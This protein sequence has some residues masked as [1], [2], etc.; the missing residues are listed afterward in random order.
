MKLL[1]EVA[2]PIG[3]NALSLSSG[4]AATGIAVVVLAPKRIGI[5]DRRAI[6][7]ISG[8]TPS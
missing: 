5:T 2:I 8:K 4:I 6:P 7:V 3:Q 1:T